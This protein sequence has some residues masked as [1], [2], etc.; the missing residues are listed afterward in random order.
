MTEL[1]D[2]DADNQKELKTAT[3]A[4]ALATHSASSF[5]HNHIMLSTAIVYAFNADGSFANRILCVGQIKSSP[6]HPTLHKTRFGWILAGRLGNPANSGQNV[7]FF[8]VSITNTQ[9][10]DQLSR[11]WLIEDVVGGS[12]NYTSDEAYCEQHFLQNVSQTPQGRLIVKLPTRE[13]VLNRLG[14]SREGALKRFY[15]LEKRFRRDPDLKLHYSQFINEYLA[16]GHMRLLDEQVDDN[17]RHFYLPHHCVFKS[18]PQSS[19][20]RVVFDASSKSSTGISLNDALL[21]GSTVQQDLISIMLRFRTFRFVLASDIIKMYRQIRVHPSQTRFQH[22]LWRSHPESNVKAFEL[23]TVTYGTSSASY[24]ATRCLKYLAERHSDKYPIGS[25]CV[26]RDFYVDNMLTGAD[27]INQIES[28]RDKTIDLLRLGAFELSK[29]ASNYPQS[30]ANL[31]GQNA[32]VV[33]IDDGTNSSILGI[34][35]NQSKDTFHFSYKFDDTLGTVS[36]QV[37]L[38]EV[39][40]LFDPLGLLGPVIVLAK[41]ILQELWQLDTHWDESVTQD[42][43]SRWSN[44]K[45]R[46]IDINQLSIPRCVKLRSE[47][48]SLQIHGFCDASQRAYGA[49]VYIRTTLEGDEYYTELLCSKSHV[50]PLKAVPLPRLELS[51]ALLLARLIEK[52]RESFDLSDMQTFLWSDSTIVLT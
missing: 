35:W 31:G 23:I 33:T 7:Q 50:A 34:H 25:I 15:S 46:L 28:I 4:L 36:K 11:F 22:I 19:K 43:H 37:I 51:A 20:I 41:L 40:R 29:W 32:N 27:T 48:R 6:K 47:P 24:L 26:K 3:S 30:L 5:E 18:T 14:D 2:R 12:D 39:S 21:V 44:L 45:S 16:M 42:L 1:R 49:C 17:S 38:L 8:E 52:I 9:L 10:Q 13:Q